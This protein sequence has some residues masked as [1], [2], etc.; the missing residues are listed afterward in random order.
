MV[1]ELPDP[2]TT[3]TAQT[4]FE[5]TISGYGTWRRLYHRDP[6]T[7][8][9][10][11]YRSVGP[12]TSRFDHHLGP[13]LTPCTEGRGIS[14]LSRTLGTAAS[15]VFGGDAVAAVCENWFVA[16][17]MPT[18]NPN[19]LDLTGAG[20]MAIGA[21]AQL[22][23]GYGV[24]ERTQA[25]SRKIYEIYPRV[26]PITIDGILYP[27]AH[28]FGECL[29]LFE[30]AG[31][32]DVVNDGIGNRDDKCLVDAGPHRDDFIAE[33]RIRRIGVNWIDEDDCDSCI[34]HRP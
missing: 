20:I 15:E 34:R 32:M 31:A 30:S 14:Y 16:T 24:H 25:W 7:P 22:A 10:D 1:A 9:G 4:R 29:A 5:R 27:G 12:T 6:Y 2:P 8:R 26:D 17:V 19:V 23:A 3:V 11:R 21:N 33:L 18:G 28:D 13:P